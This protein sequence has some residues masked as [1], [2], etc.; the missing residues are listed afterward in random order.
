MTHLDTPKLPGRYGWRL[1]LLGRAEF[2]GWHVR[3]LAPDWGPDLLLIRRPRL[4][5]IFAEPERGRLSAA[6]LASLAELRACHQVVL[7]ARPT[8]IPQVERMLS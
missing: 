5:W 8:N 2:H 6:R 4:L 1:E 3:M 7:V